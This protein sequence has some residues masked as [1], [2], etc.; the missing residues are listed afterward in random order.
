[1]S[2][3]AQEYY[4][5]SSAAIGALAISFMLAYLPFSFVA[6]QTIVHRG[7]RFAAGLG[8][9]LAG[10]SGVARGLVGANYALALLATIGAAI[11]QPFLLNAWTTISTQWFPQS[12]RATAVS[13]IT[14]ANLFGVAI[15]MA[16]DAHPGGVDVDLVGAAGVRRRRARGR[17]R[18]RPGR[19]G[20]STDPA[21]R[22][23]PWPRRHRCWSAY[24]RRWRC[25]PSWC[26]W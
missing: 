4:G 14:L 13:L 18:L 5:V 2:S 6:S 9:L 26:S 23:S 17:H 20:P 10:V 8:A 21:R 15:G 16:R 24:A 1:M 12:Q 25:A 19:P 22:Q 11:A 7:F 3:T